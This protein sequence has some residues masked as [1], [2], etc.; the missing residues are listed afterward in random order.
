MARR[1]SCYRGIGESGCVVYRPPPVG[2]AMK[3]PQ[4]TSAQTL[5]FVSYRKIVESG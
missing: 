4:F 2:F 3:S 1:L 5:S